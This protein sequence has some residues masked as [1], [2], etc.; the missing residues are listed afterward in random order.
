MIG[1]VAKVVR[2]SHKDYVGIEG[3]VVMES[4]NMIVLA[5]RTSATKRIP[6]KAVVLELDIPENGK[7]QIA[8]ADIVGRP[9]NRIKKRR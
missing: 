6:K 3:L 8:G 7:I 4:R 5:T 2:S 1:L 9:E